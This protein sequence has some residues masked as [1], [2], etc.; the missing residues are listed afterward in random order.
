M[1]IA[2]YFLTTAAAF[3]SGY[4]I[5]DARQKASSKPT[6]GPDGK[7]AKRSK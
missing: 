1:D 4:V 7:F 2:I 3:C 6:R 5:G